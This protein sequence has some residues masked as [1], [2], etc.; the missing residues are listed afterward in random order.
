GRSGDVSQVMALIH[1]EASLSEWARWLFSSTAP[2]LLFGLAIVSIISAAV[3]YLLS[4]WL[5]R[6]R[7]GRKWR[8]RLHIRETAKA[9]QEEAD[10]SLREQASC[11]P[12]G[13]ARIVAI[14]SA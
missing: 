9:R 14:C 1:N 8:N 2:T 7:M 10:F 6:G 5:W 13:R 11:K 3:G 12:S 4:I